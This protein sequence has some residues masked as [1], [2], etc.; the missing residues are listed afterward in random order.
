MLGKEE[1]QTL[2]RTW[3]LSFLARESVGVRVVWSDRAFDAE[4]D[5]CVVSRD[6]SSNTLL[7]ELIRT[8]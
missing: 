7:A 2:S 5:A 6:A 4:F 3:R 8:G 1:W